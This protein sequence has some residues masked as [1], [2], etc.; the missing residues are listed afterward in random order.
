MTFLIGDAHGAYNLGRCYE[1]GRGV[2][3]DMTVARKWYKAAK[4]G[5]VTT[6]NNVDDGDNDTMSKEP[7]SYSKGNS[8]CF[9][10]IVGAV[11]H[12]QNCRHFVFVTLIYYH[13][14]R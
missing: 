10:T 11:I 8:G 3:K 6:D 9:H 1:Y 7:S 12:R 4:V 2:K 13:Q 5:G 14:W